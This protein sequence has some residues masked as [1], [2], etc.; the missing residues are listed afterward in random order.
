MGE[1]MG[2]KPGHVL[3]CGGPHPFHMHQYKAMRTGK[4]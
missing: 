2:E 4:H 3:E 1:E